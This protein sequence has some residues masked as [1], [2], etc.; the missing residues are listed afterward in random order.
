MPMMEGSMPGAAVASPEAAV[1]TAPPEPEPAYVPSYLQADPNRQDG[2]TVYGTTAEEEAQ[3]RDNI[4]ADMQ[5]QGVGVPGEG[6]TQEEVEAWKKNFETNYSKLREVYT[7]GQLDRR[8]DEEIGN[9]LPPKMDLEDTEYGGTATLKE[10]AMAM[11]AMTSRMR[12]YEAAGK[13]GDKNAADIA[14]KMR[15]RIR[16][17]NK[18]NGKYLLH[19][20][21]IA[22]TGR[23]VTDNGKPRTRQE[24]EAADMEYKDYRAATHSVMYTDSSVG[25]ARGLDAG[26]VMYE[27]HPFGTGYGDEGARDEDYDSDFAEVQD[28]HIDSSVYSQA[29]RVA[30]QE[31]LKKH[32]GDQTWADM[33]V[34][35]FKLNQ[36]FRNE[37]AID[38]QQRELRDIYGIDRQTF[39]TDGWIG[40]T[41]QWFSDTG[42]NISNWFGGISDEELA[43]KRKA[44]E[45]ERKRRAA[46]EGKVEE[47]SG[48]GS[49]AASRFGSVWWTA[50]EPGM[51]PLDLAMGSH[52]AFTAAKGTATLA[53]AMAVA[54]ARKA[55]LG[56]G[57]RA[58]GKGTFNAAMGVGL[59]VGSAYMSAMA[60]GTPAPNVQQGGQPIQYTQG[61][62]AANGYN[63]AMGVSQQPQQVQQSEATQGTVFD[64][65]VDRIP[66]VQQNAQTMA[67]QQ[68]A[69]AGAPQQMTPAA[70]PGSSVSTVQPRTLQ[71]QPVQPRPQ[72]Q[73][74][75]Q[76]RPQQQQFV[77]PRPQQPGNTGFVSSVFGG[78][79]SGSTP[80][81]SSASSMT[82]GGSKK[83]LNLK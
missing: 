47:Y 43:Q 15:D 35:P 38:M 28:N 1:Q 68:N 71:Q 82:E 75:V 70:L 78:K 13:K 69:Q 11:A 81:S 64:E 30:N 59:P 4:V 36:T 53:K 76:P 12:A 80:S 51:L 3:I 25:K 27:D 67:P 77:Q 34:H 21:N 20:Q 37:A 57:A 54:S 23:D 52:G 74:V 41:G 26:T 9:F 2:K 16:M 60:P 62:Q 17:L 44:Q 14:T 33:M 24:I 58:L 18:M 5:A 6:A 73:Q 56:A 65:N 49:S 55:A 42:D 79:S 48:A 8:A 50:A 66:Q 61:A 72:Q 10:R 7:N 31:K 63:Q 45:A 22:L 29:A 32:Y 39:D 46:L 19:V 40:R 83:R